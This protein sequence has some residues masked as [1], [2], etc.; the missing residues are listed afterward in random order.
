MSNDSRNAY[1]LGQ[2]LL[3]YAVSRSH[4][5]GSHTRLQKSSLTHIYKLLNYFGLGDVDGSLSQLEECTSNLAPN[6]SGASDWGSVIEW[7]LQIGDSIAIRRSRGVGDHCTL[8]ALLGFLHYAVE[9]KNRQTID[10]LTVHLER[11]VVRLKTSLPEEIAREILDLCG[12]A[13]GVSSSGRTEP[14][15]LDDSRRLFESLPA[16]LEASSGFLS[17]VPP[18]QP[19]AGQSMLRQAIRLFYS[20]SH[21]NEALR[22][23]LEEALALLKRQGLISG[24]HDRRI[25]AGEEW[26][27]AIDKNLEEAQVVLLLVSSSFLA[28]DYC[29]DVETKR[30]IERH[31]RGEA[32]VIPVILRPCVWHGAPFGKLQALPKDGKAVTSWANKDKAWTDVA[33]GIRRAV[34]AMTAKP[35]EGLLVS[36]G[37]ESKKVG[38]PTN[39]G[40]PA[41]SQDAVLQKEKVKVRSMLALFDRGAFEIDLPY[42]RTAPLYRS[43]KSTR[44]KLRRRGPSTLLLH[45]VSTLFGEIIDILQN[46]Q[47]QVDDEYPEVEI[48]A[49]KP[50]RLTRQDNQELKNLMGQRYFDAANLMMSIRPEIEARLNVIR[51]HVGLKKCNVGDK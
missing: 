42:E 43:L 17:V 25:G 4:T 9:L 18:E 32:K 45:D 51:Q 38:A 27:G 21:K 3:R 29:W 28:S 30:A 1:E 20:Y 31:D 24:W 36:Q 16:I 2:S 49:D 22:D 11:Y 5:D 46:I 40:A 41:F 23:E 10:F 47:H 19:H 13:K 50:R 15:L 39:S 34:E 12:R 7:S 35:S 26:K 33:E 14:S 37:G 8:A 44:V 48:E 6:E